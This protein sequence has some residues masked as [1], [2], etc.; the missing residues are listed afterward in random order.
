MDT[1]TCNADTATLFKVGCLGTFGDYI[2][3][4]A[5]SLGA[6]GLAIAVFQVYLPT[7]EMRG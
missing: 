3:A 5:V 2:K 1:F 4:H 7:Y 6:A